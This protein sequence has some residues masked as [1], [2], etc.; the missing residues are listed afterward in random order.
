MN[1]YRQMIECLE[2]PKVSR[3]E[4]LVRGDWIYYKNDAR[5]PRK[6]PDGAWRGENAIYEGHGYFS[7]HGLSMKT[8]ADFKIDMTEM[9]NASSTAED[10]K[11]AEFDP[12][13]ANNTDGK[14]V[15]FLWDSVY[16]LDIK[17]INDLKARL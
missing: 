10:K 9:F 7:G 1:F 3:I 8:E 17:K 16:R 11:R 13:L 14:P 2:N 6:H 15:G 4:D 12:S 5:Y